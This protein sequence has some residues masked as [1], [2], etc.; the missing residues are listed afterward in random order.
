M[1]VERVLYNIK[2]IDLEKL[3]VD[4]VILNGMKFKK[5]YYAN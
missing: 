1:I 5:K 2:D 4:F 3:E